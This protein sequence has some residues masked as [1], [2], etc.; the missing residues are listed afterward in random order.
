[1]N[2]NLYRKIAKSHGVT[3]KEVKQD[4]QIAINEAYKQTNFY[5]G[6]VPH[7]GVTP[8]PDEFIAHVIRETHSR[9]A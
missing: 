6:Q 8:T 4:M 3:V 2:R 9:G 1:M 5:A 7:R